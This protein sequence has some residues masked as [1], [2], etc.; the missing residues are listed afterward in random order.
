MDRLTARAWEHA[1]FAVS[2]AIAYSYIFICYNR[3]HFETCLSNI[4]SYKAS[5]VLVMVQFSIA[6]KYKK[7][8]NS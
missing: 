3:Q 4:E 7:A 5:N 1:H 6:L 2:P 8:G